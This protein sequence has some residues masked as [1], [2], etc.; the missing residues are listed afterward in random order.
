MAYNVGD[1]CLSGTGDNGAEEAGSIVTINTDRCT[2][3][4]ICE[5]ICPYGIFNMGIKGQTPS[6]NRE[7]TAACCRCGHCGA[8]CPEDAILLSYPY[9]DPLPEHFPE[10]PVT[11]GQLMQHV[12]GRRS[13][14]HY[15]GDTVPKDVLE[16]V[17]SLVRYAP[18][19]MNHQ[20]VHWLI[21]NDPSRVRQLAGAVIAWATEMQRS[22]PDHPLASLFPVLIGAWNRGT[23]LVC[24][25]APHLVIAHGRRDDPAVFTDAV[26]ALTHLS[27]AAPAFQ[28]GTCWGGLV[29]IAFEDL[30]DLT[31]L[32]DIPEDH[33]LLHAM[34]IGYPKY[35]Y[36][37]I[38]HRERAKITWG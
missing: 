23:D 11:P 36:I 4:G 34:M 22:S 27:L 33:R 38:P 29:Q 2:G 19:G 6:V 12:A 24:H 31:R 15:T 26:I 20:T 5:N 8:V 21:I 35:H 1:E 25:G 14:R 7:R 32:L 10:P 28:L 30:P 16:Q 17:F 13:I 18:T 3:C 9:G 37:R